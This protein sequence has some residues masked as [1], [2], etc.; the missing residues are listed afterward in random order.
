[1]SGYKYNHNKDNNNNSP[2][3]PGLA[4]NTIVN[5]PPRTTPPSN[6]GKVCSAVEWLNANVKCSNEAEMIA[7]S[8]QMMPI[9]AQPLTFENCKELGKQDAMNFKQMNYTLYDQCPY[10]PVSGRS[11]Y[12]VGYGAVIDSRQP[13]PPVKAQPLTFENC[14]ELGKQDVINGAEINKILYAECPR[15]ENTGQSS[16]ITGMSDALGL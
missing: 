7:K 11:V 12:A 5:D 2:R 15:D 3:T 16:Y 6:N 14:K 10:D 8:T 9:K 1:V 4:P 13:L